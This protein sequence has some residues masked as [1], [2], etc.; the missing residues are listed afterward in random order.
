[1]AK[2]PK[3]RRALRPLY[4]YALGLILVLGIL[5]GVVAVTL[6]QGRTPPGAETKTSIK[7]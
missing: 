6:N 2:A 4:G 1:M 7:E 3:A 5:G